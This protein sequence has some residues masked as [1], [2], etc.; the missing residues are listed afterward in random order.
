MTK[1][2][3]TMARVPSA[4]LESI[5]IA[6]NE[7]NDTANK[8]CFKDGVTILSSSMKFVTLYGKT[9]VI[10]T[11]VTQP[12]SKKPARQDSKKKGLNEK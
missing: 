1:E 3:I 7:C 12:I 2:F 9:V 4:D 10:V 11:Y 8:L 5:Q 6:L